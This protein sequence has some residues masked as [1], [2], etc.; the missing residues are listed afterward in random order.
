[1]IEFIRSVFHSTGKNRYVFYFFFLIF[2]FVARQLSAQSEVTIKY[3][4]GPDRP[5]NCVYFVW[6]GQNNKRESQTINR[7][8]SYTFVTTS[9][10]VRIVSWRETLTSYRD[11]DEKTVQLEADRAITIEVSLNRDLKLDIIKTVAL[12]PQQGGV[13]GALN[14]AVKEVAE[15]FTARSRIAIIYITA[16]DRSTTEF[17]TGE[18]EHLLRRNGYVIVDRSELD[19]IRSEQQFGM[20]GEVDD[21]TAASIGKFAGANVVITGRIDGEGDLRRLRLRALDTTNAQVIG[22]ASERL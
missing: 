9:G 19:K 14:R 12:R 6:S 13:E 7:N 22:T 21:N 16:K 18:L 11:V 1:M 2:F 5:S 3:V 10:S 4:S 15:N 8:E 17:I 20:S